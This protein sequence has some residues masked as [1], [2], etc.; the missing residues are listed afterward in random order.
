[1]S[2][3]PEVRRVVPNPKIG[4]CIVATVKTWMGTPHRGELVW[5]SHVEC[6][7]PGWVWLVDPDSCV[8]DRRLTKVELLPRLEPQPPP[9]VN[10]HCVPLTEGTHRSIR[11]R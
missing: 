10:D 3:V 9:E 11:Q 1:M 2:D 4:D 6:R 5:M 7:D 8:D